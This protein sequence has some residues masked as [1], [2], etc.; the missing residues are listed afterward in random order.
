METLANANIAI[1]G[2]IQFLNE[3]SKEEIN[4]KKLVVNEF[5]RL[6]S[7][8]EGQPSYTAMYSGISRLFEN[9]VVVNNA[10]LPYSTKE[11]KCLNEL[12]IFT[13]RIL[14]VNPV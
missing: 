3:Q 2:V 10:A 6:L 9:F 5:Q 14:A 7:L 12:S 4:H 13:L 1:R 8:V 11:L